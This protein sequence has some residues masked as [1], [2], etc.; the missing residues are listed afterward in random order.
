[1]SSYDD[2]DI[3]DS[4][5]APAE[6]SD[7]PPV[8][9]EPP[10]PE[11]APV[12]AQV[13]KPVSRPVTPPAKTVSE[14]IAESGGAV[15]AKAKDAIGEGAKS[16]K[17]AGLDK[18]ARLRAANAANRAERME[19]P[20]GGAPGKP[21]PRPVSRPA[22]PVAQAPVQEQAPAPAKPVEEELVGADDYRV[23]AKPTEQGKMAAPTVGNDL[24]ELDVVDDLAAAGES[25]AFAVTNLNR[26]PVRMMLFAGVLVLIGALGYDYYRTQERLKLVEANANAAAVAKVPANLPP[27]APPTAAPATPPAPQAPAEQ[28]LLPKPEGV[29]APATPAAPAVPGQATPPATTAPADAKPVAPEAK[30]EAPKLDFGDVKLPPPPPPDDALAATT[31][32]GVTKATPGKSGSGVSTGGSARAPK[33]PDGWDARKRQM[34]Q[35]LKNQRHY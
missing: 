17:E 22:K 10:K 4:D 28:A 18:A 11:P 19:R 25:K 6:T 26:F 24:V 23:T 12:P 31:N 30:K 15:L 1:M 2:W 33:Q 29:T 16:V 3:S 35:F 20:A 7:T 13:S 9:T 27:V 32:P 5:N 34:E 14:R 21:A 8:K